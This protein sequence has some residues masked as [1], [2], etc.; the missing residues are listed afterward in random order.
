MSFPKN[1]A[2][3]AN[4]FL[5]LPFGRYPAQSRSIHMFVRR[6]GGSALIKHGYNFFLCYRAR[7]HHEQSGEKKS[8]HTLSLPQDEPNK[9]FIAFPLRLFKSTAEVRAQVI[10]YS[11]L[12]ACI[13][14]PV[15]GVGAQAR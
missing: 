2:T 7:G 13:E 14:E 3:E 1:R 12:S 4:R 8:S 5:G 10:F 9:E 11:N 6:C 15:V